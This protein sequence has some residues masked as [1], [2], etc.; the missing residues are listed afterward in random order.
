MVENTSYYQKMRREVISRL[1]CLPR[2]T[3]K[4]RT[5]SGNRYFYLQYR[6]GGKVIQKYLGTNIP[7]QLIKHL[8][9]RKLLEKE[10]KKIEDALAWLNVSPDSDIFKPLMEVIKALNPDGFRE[11]SVELVGS[12]AFRL[13]Q[14]HYGVS[15]FPLRTDDPDFAIFL[16]YKGKEINI[17]EF[18]KEIGFREGFNPDGSIYFYQPGLRI[19]FLVPEKGKEKKKPVKIQRLSLVA[20]PLRFLELLFYEPAAVKISKGV[21]IKIP[22]MS[23]FLI[24]KLIVFQRRQNK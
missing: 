10:L 12:W 23:A 5:I 21:K 13:Y 4:T 22:S 18:L 8:K 15:F 24:H 11:E 16:P 9:E 3:I 19:D 20:Q 2:G 14:Q 1:A 6:R 7:E 17:S